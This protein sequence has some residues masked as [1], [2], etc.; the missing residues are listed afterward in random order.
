MTYDILFVGLDISKLKHDVAIMNENKELLCR[1][2]IIRENR[3][4]YQYF[5]NR[6]DQLKEKHQTKTF[7]IGMESTADYWKNIFYFLK[8]QSNGFIP[9]LINPV[10]TKAF[11]KASTEELCRICYGKKQWQFPVSFAAKMNNLAQNSIAHKSGLGA[12]LVVQ[13]LVRH[14]FQFQQEIQILK[15]QIKQLY[16]NTSDNESLLTSIK[17]IGKETAIVL[18]AYFGD[19]NRFPNAKK[20]VAYF[21]MNPTVNQSGKKTKRKSYLEKKGSGIV[22][23][24]LYMATLNMIGRKQEPIYTYYQRLVAAGKAK[25]VAMGAAMRKLLVIM[26]TMLKNQEKFDPNKYVN[27]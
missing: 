14:I 17:G 22:R 12:G 20:F 11:A 27:H 8:K 18:E 7:Y 2:F 15:E 16:E 5:I 19:V 4:G 3:A 13:A 9:V 6:L 21:G 1:P 25:L 23:Y 10:Q 24:K 26:Y